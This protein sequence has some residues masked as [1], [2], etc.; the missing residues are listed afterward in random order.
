MDF[1]ALL[2]LI[3]GLV[4]FLTLAGLL[5][6]RPEW[7]IPLVALGAAAT[8]S[9]F[10]RA[11]SSFAGFAVYIG[12]AA[13]AALLVALGIQLLAGRPLRRPAFGWAGL[14]LLA[15]LALL[16]GLG[17]FG[18][19]AVVQS[20]RNELQLLCA[21]LFFAAQQIPLARVELFL[22]RT[23]V[24]IGICMSAIAIL[25]VLR[26]GLNSTVASR[27]RPLNASQA[28]FVS[29]AIFFLLARGRQGKSNWLA[30]YFGLIVLISQQRTVW[31]ATVLAMFALWSVLAPSGR[32]KQRVSVA[33]GTL[34]ALLLAFMTALSSTQAG[35][36]LQKTLSQDG[37]FLWRVEGWGFLV[38][39]QIHGLGL[40]L[41]LGNPAGKGAARRVAGQSIT[42][43]AHSQWITELLAGGIIALILFALVTVVPLTKTWRQDLNLRVP[44]PL[45]AVTVAAM[46]FTISYQLG[47]EQG[48]LFGLLGATLGTQA[49]VANQ[50]SGAEEHS[51]VEAHPSG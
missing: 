13:A 19:Q 23:W 4:V 26:Y 12:D 28:L 34:V 14:L 31:I 1:G 42:V 49:A 36:A 10:T 3:T 8:V 50:A 27:D 20:Y 43:S 9:G 40:N 2:V 30:A 29:Q 18:V 38:S 44:S 15:A 24:A 17:A 48:V 11:L 25:F 46:T 22:R 33:V 5:V 7:G 35:I 16:R 6:D 41:A 45:L 37:T 32:M 21:G 39:Q 51:V 47:P